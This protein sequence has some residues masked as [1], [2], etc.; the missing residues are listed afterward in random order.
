MK[1]FLFLLFLLAAFSST[2]QAGE[3]MRIATFQSFTDDNYTFQRS[4]KG[5]AVNPVTHTTCVPQDGTLEIEFLDDGMIVNIKNLVYGSEKEF[6]D[7]LVYGYAD[8]NIIHIP[9]GQVI[10]SERGGRQAVLGW[11]SVSYNA[12]TGECSFVPDATVSEIV[13]SLDDKSIHIESTSGPVVINDD[14]EFTY[15]AAGPAIIWQDAES[16]E[17]DGWTGYC[18]WGTELPYYMDWQ[19]EGELKTYDRTS[20]CIHYSYGWSK[21]TNATF[22]QERLTGQ[23]EIVFSQ[24]GKTVYF[25]DLLQSMSYGTWVM[26]SLNDDGTIITVNIPQLLYC[27]D[28]IVPLRKCE[29]QIVYQNQPDGTQQEELETE[30]LWASNIRFAVE[31]NT[32]TLLDTWAD[33]NATYPGNYAA[34]GL[35]T[36]DIEDNAG[37]VEANI[38]YTLRADEPVAVT[39]KPV[40]NGYPIDNGHAYCIEITPTEP[41]TIYYRIQDAEGNSTAWLTYESTVVIT[42]PGVYLIEAYAQAD[43]KQPSEYATHDFKVDKSTSVSE[44]S[45]GK[46]VV[47]KRYLN[48]MGQETGQPQGL[49]I[50]VTT[51]SDGTTSAVKVMK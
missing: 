6:G 16:E 27:T 32:I 46:Q 3:P 19:P 26:G 36:Y 29:S 11:G 18:E 45:A 47:S 15:N 14:E 38:V 37:A 24:D 23:S 7:Y 1:K 20:D 34:R 12:A 35:Y 42:A 39:S 17:Y 4:A 5:G 33:F 25:K 22:S 13:Y 43:G 9:L 2:V 51:Y 8:E 40:I 28:D 44:T 10:Y 48:V 31:G 49:T 30:D 21:G 41:S 50:V